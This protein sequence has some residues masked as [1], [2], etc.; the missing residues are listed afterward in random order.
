MSSEQSD[1]PKQ[2]IDRFL[3]AI[4]KKDEHGK[5]FSDYV[6]ESM[7]DF[8]KDANSFWDNLS[9]EDKL[10]AFF[11]VCERIHKG[12]LKDRGSY[13]YVLYQVFGFDMDAYTLGIECGY[14]DIHNSIVSEEDRKFEDKRNQIANE[15]ME[16]EQFMWL[17]AGS[18]HAQSNI[19]ALRPAYEA[20]IRAG[21]KNIFKK[22]P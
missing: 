20:W 3:E 1:A 10:K 16:S 2:G 8:R 9:Y 12:D 15:V 21:G 6:H 4:N 19:A 18:N 14:L 22:E 5:S 7:D 13:R 17:M 11:A